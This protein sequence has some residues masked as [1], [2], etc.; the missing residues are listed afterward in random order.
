MSNSLS[1]DPAELR[2]SAA[3]LLRQAEEA[4]QMLES[5]KAIIAEQGKCWGDDE[6]GETFGKNYEPDSERGVEGF[7]DIVADLRSMSANLQN[8]AAEFE[9]QDRRGA[10]QITDPTVPGTT[11]ALLPHRPI[12]AGISPDTSGNPV[13]TG[14][15]GVQQTTGVRPVAGRTVAEASPVPEPAVSPGADPGTGPGPGDTSQE[16]PE[17]RRSPDS[18]GSEPPGAE[19]P[20]TPE[21][22]PANTVPNTPA[23]VRDTARPHGTSPAPAPGRQPETPAP[24]SSGTPAGKPATE[25]PWSQSKPNRP[26]A[27]PSVFPAAPSGETPPRVSPPQT[28]ARP[29]HNPGAK[30]AEQAKRPEKKPKPQVAQPANT[31]TDP[32]AMR[33]LREMAARHGLSLEGFESTGLDVRAAQDI[34]DAV[35]LVLVRYPT[36]LCGIAISEAADS[37]ASVEN[38][39]KAA[40]RGAVAPWIVLTRHAAANPRSAADRTPGSNTIPD[41]PMYTTILGQ[42]GAAFDLMGGFRARNEAQRTLI[43]EYL[44]LHGAQGETLG[45]VVAG[46]KRWRA[47]L[48]KDCFDHGVLVPARA[49]AAGFVEVETKYDTASSPAKVL[50][51]ALVAMAQ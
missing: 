33:I 43:A 2:A 12:V 15:S 20:G 5:I 48:G 6:L 35:D 8:S 25:S 19:P 11:Q 39:A 41:R 17:S 9:Q 4:E 42:L 44:R 16:S 37:P 27:R 30:P 14:D 36:V 47:R 26:G 40:A 51:R 49:L 31:P 29:P 46:Y 23:A 22:S 50:H 32:E 3:K 34:A 7:A 45:Q 10:Q 28:P 18:P 21:D 24:R 13:P 38:R 1:V